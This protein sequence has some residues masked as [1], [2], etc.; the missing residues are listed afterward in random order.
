[1]DSQSD[2]SWQTSAWWHDDISSSQLDNLWWAAAIQ[3]PDAANGTAGNDFCLPAAIDSD[4]PSSFHGLDGPAGFSLP[5]ETAITADSPSLFES[6]DDEDSMMMSS[7]L[8]PSISM[9]YPSPLA[10]SE[11]DNG[12]SYDNSKTKTK[13]RRATS[14]KTRIGASA[15][16]SSSKR[17]SSSSDSSSEPRLQRARTC[18][19]VVEKNYRNR[20]NGQ[21]ELMLATLNKTRA[22]EGEM[23]SFDGD[24][25]APSKSAVLQ[26]ARERVISL[27]KENEQLRREVERLRDTSRLEFSYA[28]TALI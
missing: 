6:I 21:F 15:G 4:P 17:K 26:L 10:S 23:E 25:R 14:S 19:N 9:A 20:L 16:K 22:R 2:A 27:E 24:D 11:S 8:T 5:S 28:R 13:S 12:A 3:A 18:H 7:P 1:M